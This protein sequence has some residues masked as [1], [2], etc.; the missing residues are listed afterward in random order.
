MEANCVPHYLTYFLLYY[1]TFYSRPTLISIY[2][3][4]NSPFRFSHVKRQS[5]QIGKLSDV[6]LMTPGTKLLRCICCKPFFYRRWKMKKGNILNLKVTR[7][8]I[9]RDITENFSYGIYRCTCF[10]LFFFSLKDVW[11]CN[12]YWVSKWIL[13]AEFKTQPQ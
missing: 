3:S 2:V 5:W 1:S 6:T 7:K 4:K 8:Y 11:R 12:W 10:F 9:K 13:Q